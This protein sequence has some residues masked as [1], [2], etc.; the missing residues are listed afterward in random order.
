MNK[1]RTTRQHSTR[2]AFTLLELI[3]VIGIISLLVAAVIFVS[4]GIIRSQKA[5]QTENLLT[6]LDRA[7]DEF[8]L[9]RGAFPFYD[10]DTI[11]RYES[12]FNKAFEG[13][14]S[15]PES[16]AGRAAGPILT[17]PSGARR[18]AAL[19]DAWIFYDQAQGFGAVDDILRNLPDSATR[20]RIIDNPSASEPP[21]LVRFVD[22]WDN[23][24]IFV[25]PDNDAAQD[26]FG[27]CQGGRPYF[28]S[29]GPDERFGFFEEITGNTNLPGG[30]ADRVVISET[31][32][33]IE[34]NIYSAQP[35]RFIPPTDTAD[36]A[37]T[38]L[39]TL[40]VPTR[41]DP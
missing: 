6:T 23:K 16:R 34:N 1:Q 13:D 30:D 12:V 21:N 24:I 32:D 33:A 31:R 4:P 19:P 18:Q 37:T 14:V 22:A 20:S 25:H 36:E 2:N 40:N 3:V 5:A 41:N 27:A 38:T 26:L 39:R 17:Y 9:A 10:E 35:G 11:D 15:D 7:L 28:M 8:Q 29:P